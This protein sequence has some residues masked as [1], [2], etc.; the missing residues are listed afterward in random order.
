[1]RKLGGVKGVVNLIVVRP[2]IEA[3]FVRAK[4][5]AA[6]ERR[7]D[8][9]ASRIKVD[10]ID[11]KVMLT[12]EV[13]NWLEREEAERAAWSVPGVMEVDDQITIARP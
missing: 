2:K 10:V 11:G 9:E 12:G 6:L 13:D 4:L 8:I 7:A 5:T 1:M 3:A